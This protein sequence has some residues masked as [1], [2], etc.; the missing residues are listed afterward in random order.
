MTSLV[1]FIVIFVAAGLT[2]LAATWLLGPWLVPLAFGDDFSPAYP[3]LVTQMIAVI[4]LMH[5]G[6]SRS[7]LLAMGR[8]RLVLYIALLGAICFFATAWVLVDQFGAIGATI[9]H[10][11]MAAIIAL[12]MDL[13]WL[14][15]IRRPR[16]PSAS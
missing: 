8:H 13:A 2:L 15:A 4:F 12:L 10:I 6:P 7:A 9:S 14:R 5:A 1:L 11:V 16:P 3:L